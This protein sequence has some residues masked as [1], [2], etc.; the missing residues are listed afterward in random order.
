MKQNKTPLADALINNA[1]DEIVSFDVPG[2]KSNILELSEYFGNQ[3]IKFDKNSRCSID[4]LCQ[5]TGVIRE[6]EDLAAEAFGAKNAFFMIGGT[7]SSV[8]A[9]IMSTCTHGDKI[10]LPRNVHS[11]VLNGIILAGALPVYINPGTHDEL[12]ISLGMSL[13]D[14]KQT[15]ANNTD[16][17]AI[18]VN[19]PTYYGI[20]SDLEEIVKIAHENNIFVL[21][22]EAHG[23]HFYFHDQLPKSA[24]Q[25]GADMTAVSMHKT[26]GSL[27]QSSLLL[28]NNDIDEEHVRSIINLSRTTS[29]SYLLMASLDIARKKMALEGNTLLNNLLSQVKK[30]RDMINAIGDYYAFAEEIIGYKTIY[31]FDKTKLSIN[32]SNLGLSGVE[33]YKLLRDKYKIQIEFGDI[34]NILAVTSIADKEENFEILLKALKSIKEKYKTNNMIPFKYEY[35][36]PIIKM[37]P[38]KAFYSMQKK[39]LINSSKGYISGDY[40]MCYPPGIPI[41]APGEQ[42]TQ[43][44]IDLIVY[45]TEKGCTISGLGNSTPEF[46]NVLL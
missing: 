45:S 6:S 31:D 15:I 14:V 7:T 24:F 5:P 34:R 32:T 35:I 46:I 42:I 22:D 20:C 44:I 33:V 16:A 43:E 21:V 27:T 13:D 8:Q 23:T 19:N 28:T 30:T 29:A 37:S 41:L 40:I 9:M 1:T 10:I 17:K 2:H 39:I 26:G 11:S 36:T 12:G 4:N 18:F 25:C 38:S 3:C